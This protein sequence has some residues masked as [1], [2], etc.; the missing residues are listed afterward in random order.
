MFKAE[1]GVKLDYTNRSQLVVWI[2][3]LKSPNLSVLFLPLIFIADDKRN[4]N[5]KISPQFSVRQQ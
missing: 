5:L 2:S 4:T 3:F 1:E